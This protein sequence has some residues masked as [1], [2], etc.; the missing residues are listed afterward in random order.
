MNEDQCLKAATM[1]SMPEPPTQMWVP[2]LS[3]YEIH[4]KFYDVGCT[5]SVGCKTIAFND[6]KEG[7]KELN[8]YINNHRETYVKWQKLFN[9]N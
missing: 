5:I 1:E 3:E 4:I 7:I 2:Q 8:E 6:Y 9:N